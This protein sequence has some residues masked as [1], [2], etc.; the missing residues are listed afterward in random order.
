MTGAAR[1]SC[2]GS[3]WQEQLGQL[4][5]LKMAGAAR[6]SFFHS[7]LTCRTTCFHS[8]WSTSSIH[9]SL[10]GSASLSIPHNTSNWRWPLHGTYGSCK[11]TAV[12]NDLALGHGSICTGWLIGPLQIYREETTQSLFNYLLYTRLQ[13]NSLPLLFA[14]ELLSLQ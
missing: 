13:Q 4:L 10:I 7:I 2:Y 9:R 14:T 1:V 11:D 3:K 6:A 8:N 12:W 5:W